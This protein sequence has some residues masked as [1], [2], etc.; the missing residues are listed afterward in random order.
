MS[1]VPL[2]CLIV[3]DEIQSYLDFPP[4]TQ[5]VFLP[6]ISIH[7]FLGWAYSNRAAVSFSSFCLLAG[8]N[9]FSS[10]GDDVNPS[11]KKWHGKIGMKAR[12]YP[13]FV[14]EA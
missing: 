10:Y 1:L 9:V 14:S 5:M 11:E 2:G 3:E 7:G 12:R 4:A 6:E 8:L 13:G